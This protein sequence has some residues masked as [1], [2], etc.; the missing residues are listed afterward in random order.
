[1]HAS[2]AEAELLPQEEG[3]RKGAHLMWEGPKDHMDP[4]KGGSLVGSGAVGRGGQKVALGWS[5][6][7]QVERSRNK[8]GAGQVGA[9]HCTCG[10]LHCHTTGGR[11]HEGAAGTLPGAGGSWRYLGDTGGFRNGPGASGPTGTERGGT[12]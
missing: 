9:Q 4:V 11:T 12:Q 8:M 5:Q 3:Q 2:R 6:K 10:G 7:H 1:M